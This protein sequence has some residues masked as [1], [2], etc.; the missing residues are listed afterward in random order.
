LFSSSLPLSFCEFFF[1]FRKNNI[2]YDKII[3]FLEV[4]YA[5]FGMYLINLSVFRRTF[6]QILKIKEVNIV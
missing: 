3:K 5:Y 6:T 1:Y 4:F 2:K